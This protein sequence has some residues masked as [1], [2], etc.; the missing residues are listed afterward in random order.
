M[1][2]TTAVRAAHFFEAGGNDQIESGE[3]LD[4]QSSGF[5]LVRVGSRV[6]FIETSALKAISD[7]AAAL[8]QGSIHARGAI[9][10]REFSGRNF[11]GKVIADLEFHALLQSVDH[12]AGECGVTVIVTSSFRTKD[13]A[14][15]GAIV[16]P[17]QRSNHLVG[18]AI[19]MNLRFNGQR[20]NS[21]SLLRQN[22]KLLPSNVQNFIA[23]IRAHPILRWGGDFVKADPVHIDDDL[24]RRNPELWNRKFADAP[25]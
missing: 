17:A 13:A 19:D 15:A 6:G 5:S 14:V 8:A 4:V 24:S 21:T 2:Q 22:L 11:E 1:T 9:D 25:S 20:F 16:Q 10:L 12:S 7:A 3:T 18:H 23:Q